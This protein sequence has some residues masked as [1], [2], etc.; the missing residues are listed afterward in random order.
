MHNKIKTAAG[1]FCIRRFIIG[2]LIFLFSVKMGWVVRLRRIL[3]FGFWVLGFGMGEVAGFP[4]V[5]FSLRFENDWVL[6]IRD[7][8]ILYYSLFYIHY[9]LFTTSA[10]SREGVLVLLR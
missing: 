9:S 5:I 3:D 7:F 8:T 1:A 6:T 4:S 10:S 2:F